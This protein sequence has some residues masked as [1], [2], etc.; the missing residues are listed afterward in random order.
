MKSARSS[1]IDYLPSRTSGISASFDRF[2]SAL[3]R[4]IHLRAGG[5][6]HLR[7]LLHFFLEVGAEFI[8]RA[9]KRFRSFF[10]HQGAH[11][12][13]FQYLR[14]FGVES[15]DDFA[16]G[17]G[18]KEHAVPKDERPARAAWRKR[19]APEPGRAPRC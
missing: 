10:R 5:F 6:Y 18:G 7:V 2:F 3:D 14:H 4:L 15:V 17:A 12:R 19:A 1:S 11:V 16:R 8:G 13:V 9:A